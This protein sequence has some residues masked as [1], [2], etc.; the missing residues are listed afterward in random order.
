MLKSSWVWHP[1]PGRATGYWRGWEGCALSPHRL[2]LWCWSTPPSQGPGLASLVHLG[3]YRVFAASIREP[4]RISF[5]LPWG[6]QSLSFPQ[7]WALLPP[8]VSRHSPWMQIFFI[9]S[10]LPPSLCNPNPSFHLCPRHPW[11]THPPTLPSPTCHHFPSQALTLLFLGTL[12]SWHRGF[13]VLG[14]PVRLGSGLSTCRGVE[15][16]GPS[17][18]DFALPVSLPQGHCPKLLCGPWWL[19]GLHSSRPS[20]ERREPL[21]VCRVSEYEPVANVH[22][23]TSQPLTSQSLVS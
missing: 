10:L 12:A 1:G 7:E 17:P 2:C 16:P 4:L 22:P 14:L 11:A 23:Q 15:R 3:M 19:S 6:P 8:T 20:S 18:L 5:L 21:G 9:M 13:K